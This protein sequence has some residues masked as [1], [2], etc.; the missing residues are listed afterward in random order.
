MMGCDIHILAE[1]RV[2][3]KWQKV[4]SVFVSDYSFEKGKLVDAP[5]SGRNYDLFAILANVRNGYGFAGCDTG[6]GFNPISTPRGL[7]D[8]VSPEM[9][10]YS[11]EYG[12]DGHSHSWLT[13][14]E[15]IDFDWNQTTKQRGWVDSKEFLEWK[16]KGKPGSWS[17][18][19]SGGSVRH[20]T[21][22]EMD[23]RI[24]KRK[25]TVDFYCSVEWEE[26]YRE[27]CPT[28][29]RKTIPALRKLGEP[30]NIRI[31]FFFDN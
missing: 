6:D 31:V 7:P 13:L 4:G 29:I 11:N 17:G 20:I 18:G 27:S 25:S 28:F 5:Y 16:I 19:V 2:D 3:G 15:L 10:K 1:V 24:E 23:E 22:Q 8:D 14:R 30:E 26:T 12:I 21:W 9:K